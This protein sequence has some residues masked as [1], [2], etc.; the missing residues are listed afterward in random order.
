MRVRI[1]VCG[2]A[3]MLALPLAAFGE[4]AAKEKNVTSLA[5]DT[6]A[7]TTKQEALKSK[8][9]VWGALAYVRKSDQEKDVVIVNL[10]LNEVGQE[11]AESRAFAECAARKLKS[12][13]VLTFAGCMFAVVGKSVRHDKPVFGTNPNPEHLT[14]LCR[15]KGFQCSYPIGGCNYVDAEGRNMYKR[16]AD[17][18]P[19]VN[20]SEFFVSEKVF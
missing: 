18:S 16:P 17:E 6:T 10:I 7:E 8:H 11:V 13:T 15:E 20:S 5:P 9:K 3:L 12:C 14:R 1:A 4:G 2:C 19:L